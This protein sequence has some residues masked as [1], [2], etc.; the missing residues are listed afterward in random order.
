MIDDV[1]DDDFDEFEESSEETYK[2]GIFICFL[3]IFNRI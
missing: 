1:I 2:N 3:K